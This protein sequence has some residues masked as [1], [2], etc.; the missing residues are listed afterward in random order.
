VT[1]A[2]LLAICANLVA[3]GI[4]TIAVSHGFFA[5][6]TGAVIMAL[7][8]SAFYLIA[9]HRSDSASKRR[10]RRPPHPGHWITNS[11]EYG[12]PQRFCWTNDMA[13]TQ[14]GDLQVVKTLIVQHHVE[15][16]AK[17]NRR[18]SQSFKPFFAVAYCVLFSLRA[19]KKSA[20][21][22]KS[23]RAKAR[24]R[25]LADRPV[26]AS[27]QPLERDLIIAIALVVM[28]GLMLLDVYLWH[29]STYQ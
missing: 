23:Y 20:K 25:K 8:G 10:D 19:K 9:S 26:I 27:L 16:A 24:V 18:C 1:K 17:L 12:L 3:Y 4:F 28:V 13:L 7:G 2:L 29:P 22:R 14:S 15:R 5:Q 11:R 21:M 6:L